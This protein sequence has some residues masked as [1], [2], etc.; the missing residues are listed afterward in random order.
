MG[1]FENKLFPNNQVIDSFILGTEKFSYTYIK[2]TGVLLL[3]LFGIY[4][5]I[6][7][8]LWFVLLS[9]LVCIISVLYHYDQY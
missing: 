5:I 1:T 2:V 3:Y 9:V 6:S 8:S 7:Q 4:L